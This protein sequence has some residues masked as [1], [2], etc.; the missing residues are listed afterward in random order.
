M[1]LIVD[2]DGIPQKVHAMHHLGVGCNQDFVN[3]VERYRFMP[4]TSNG[5]P[6]PASLTIEVLPTHRPHYQMMVTNIE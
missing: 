1:A 5:K 6:V 2:E 4:A 3:S